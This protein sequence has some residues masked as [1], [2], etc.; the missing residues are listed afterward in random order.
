MISMLRVRS[1]NEESDAIGQLDELLK[2]DCFTS[3]HI[4]QCSSPDTAI[5]SAFLLRLLQIL[6]CAGSPPWS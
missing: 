3:V 6:P 2:C 4:R 5:F 1:R